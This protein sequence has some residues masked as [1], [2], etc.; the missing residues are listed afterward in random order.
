MLEVK[1]IQDSE[2][3]QIYIN[4]RPNREKSIE[5]ILESNILSFQK[6]IIILIDTSDSMNSHLPLIKQSLL[7]FQKTLL[8]DSDES[9]IDLCFREL[10][11][12]KVYTY[13]EYVEKIWDNLCST[14]SYMDTINRV[15]T[16]SIS[17]LGK[18]LET[19]FENLIW[20]NKYYWLLILTDG[21]VNYGK[22]RTHTSFNRLLEHKPK[23]CKIITLG[24]GYEIN[25]ELLD[26]IGDFLYVREEKIPCIFGG[27]AE[28]ILRSSIFNINIFIEGDIQSR[29]VLDDEALIFDVKEMPGEI[30]VGETHLYNLSD[31]YTIIYKPYGSVS[32]I[33]LLKSYKVRIE[34]IELGIKERK[35]I[36]APIEIVSDS[37]DV[38]MIHKEIIRKTYIRLYTYL[39]DD[40]RYN[41]KNMIKDIYIKDDELDEFIENIK[42]ELDSTYISRSVIYKSLKRPYAYKI[43]NTPKENPFVKT[44]MKNVGS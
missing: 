7:D 13:N 20:E 8:G 25:I 3:D 44:L 32:D 21:N 40:D 18:G 5:K 43:Y 26:H 17:N 34:Y 31:D 10:I 12:V 1:G 2:G 9:I 38:N 19:I 22:Y 14:D 4:L 37:P 11:N 27:L 28:D 24:Y 29:E 15:D 39:L 23:N 35:S 33:Q 6:E 30:L 42:N 41:L 16:S 36:I